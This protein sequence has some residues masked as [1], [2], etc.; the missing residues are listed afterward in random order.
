MLVRTV[1]QA[2][3]V[4]QKELLILKSSSL[5]GRIDRRL[6]GALSRGALR[7]FGKGES[8]SDEES[9][10]MTGRRGALP[11][12]TM[13]ESDS[14]SESESA[15]TPVPTLGTLGGTLGSGL[16]SLLGGHSLYQSTVV[17]ERRI[18]ANSDEGD[19]VSVSWRAAAMMVS[20]WP[21][22][23]GCATLIVV[24]CHILFRKR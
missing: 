22:V 14:E 7:M 10:L 19:D 5:A 23:L 15:T 21:E 4:L 1:L 6:D 2:G 24:K 8:S 18:D 9:E 20:L 16:L 11:L 12:R 3:P 17:E 13:G